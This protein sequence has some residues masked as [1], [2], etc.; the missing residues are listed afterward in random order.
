MQGTCIVAGQ[1]LPVGFLPWTCASHAALCAQPLLD[2]AVPG[3]AVG[4]HKR[5][6][7]LRPLIILQGGSCKFQVALDSALGAWIL[8]HITGREASCRTDEAYPAPAVPFRVV[9]DALV[10]V[11]NGV[12]LSTG[13]A[14]PCRRLVAALNALLATCGEGPRVCV[15]IASAARV[16]ACATRV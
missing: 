1:M 8:L 7:P 13:I 11:H 2:F 10:K 3:D 15:P 5:G 14:M 16:A 6:V 9:E 12:L 4:A